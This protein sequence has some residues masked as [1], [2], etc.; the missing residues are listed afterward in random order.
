MHSFRLLSFLLPLAA[1]YNVRRSALTDCLNNAQVPILLT[2]SPGWGAEVE[3]YNLRFTPAPAVVTIPRNKKD[4]QEAVKCASKTGTRVTVKS[5]GHS[6]GAF[7][8]VGTMVMDMMEFQDVTYDKNTQIASVGTGVR[9][10]NLATKIFQLGQRGL[11]HGTCPGVGIGGHAT[12]G[13][14]GLDSRMWGLT[15]DTVVSLDV[16]LADGTATTASKTKNPDLYWA[17]RGAGP[18]FAVVTTFHLKTLPAPPV[19]INYGYTYTFT[20]ADQAAKAYAIAQE[21]GQKKA[22][23]ELG[24]GILL[25]P[26]GSFFVRGVYYGE[27]AKFDALIAPLLVLLKEAHGGKDPVTSVQTLGWIE[28]LTALAGSSLTTPVKGYNLHDT[29]YAKSVVTH[30]S[31]PLSPK[32]LKGLFNY[33]YTTT[34]PGGAQWFIISNLEGGPGSVID[35]FPPNTDPHSTSSYAHRDTGYVLQLYG[36]TANS[37]PPF[38]SGIINFV[39]GM[40][41][42]MGP[43]AAN[44]PAYAPYADPELSVADAH[45]RYWGGGVRRLM[46][47]K[48]EV[49]PKGV[50]YNPQGF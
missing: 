27:K 18:G 15:L 20:T 48:K 16:V 39:K 28:S 10:G 9:L 1:A 30:E 8:L 42:S 31:A 37:K 24:Y 6:Y 21:W 19:N 32:A 2:S 46:K 43:E 41:D 47:I 29:F 13:G 14:F 35:S 5:G 34:P 3:P 50:L 17:L 36:F 25:F 49:D 23:K 40:V 7:G 38:N 11:P 33:L 26:K 4:V 45:V 12:L 44:L 22:P